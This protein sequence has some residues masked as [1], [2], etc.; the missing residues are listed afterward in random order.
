[1]L[2]MQQLLRFKGAIVRKQVVVQ[3]VEQRQGDITGI[4][5][6]K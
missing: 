1:M 2:S 5:I 6:W 4:T 3:I